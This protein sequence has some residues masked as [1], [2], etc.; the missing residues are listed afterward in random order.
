MRG[1]E[2][3]PS[4]QPARVHVF[5]CC[6]PRDD[7]T[8]GI[9]AAR[10][11]ERECVHVRDAVRRRHCNA[12]HV[13]NH[14]HRACGPNR[15]TGKKNKIDLKSTQAL[16]LESSHF[17]HFVFVF[18]PVHLS[19]GFFRR[20]SLTSHHTQRYPPLKAHDMIVTRRPEPLSTVDEVPKHSSTSPNTHL[21]HILLVILI[22]Y[23][24]TFFSTGLRDSPLL[25]SSL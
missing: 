18:L 3:G 21:F 17:F 23:S 24:I 14:L 8:G 19:R 9:R 1:W 15:R 25:P 13:A 6:P 2:N 5:Q 7:V 11:D 12:F 22:H 4:I 16:A 10:R 20:G